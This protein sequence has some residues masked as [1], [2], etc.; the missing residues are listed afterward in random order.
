MRLCP[1]C[2][3][4][5]SDK[6]VICRACGRDVRDVPATSPDPSPIPSPSPSGTK[7]C[8]FCAED[9]QYAA[10]VCRFCGR[11]LPVDAVRP[12]SSQPPATGPLSVRRPPSPT[13]KPDIRSVKAF[14]AF[15][16]SLI[17][18]F[19]LFGLAIRS[20]AAAVGL[21]ALGTCWIA[22]VIIGRIR[23]AIPV[24]GSLSRLTLRRSG[25]AVLVGMCL[26]GGAMMGLAAGSQDRQKAAAA[27]A[28]AEATQRLAAERRVKALAAVEGQVTALQKS[29]EAK[30]WPTALRLEAS[31]RSVS[32]DRSELKA[33]A[34]V[35]AEARVEAAWSDALASARAVVS[36]KSLCDTPKAI[37]EAWNKLRALDRS[38]GDW[39]SAVSLAAR[40]ERCRKQAEMHLT[41][42]LKETMIQQRREWAKR[43]ET[44]SLDQGMDVDFTL[45]GAGR[46]H[47]KVKWALMSKAV[48]HK[49]TGGGS[50]AD[51]AFLS[52]AQKM[53]CRR[54]SFTDGWQF[55]V[56]YDLSPMD[57]STGGQTVLAQMGI[58]APLVL[59]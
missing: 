16:G 10:V 17:L 2:G 35:L 45:E 53:G 55:S 21:L 22:T 23:P 32:P 39:A 36:D 9:I 6:A 51:G 27:R 56:Y 58:G 57:E 14:G 31:I 52:S 4:A 41:A 47:L 5:M 46:D 48:V 37:S 11:D 42:G 50:M 3:K 20:A 28:A 43:M 30:D 1:H 40:L 49:I 24:V 19:F 34:P 59:R 44:A 54:V 25:W 13:A 26:F 18:F 33:L 38:K 12:A 8:P 15:V 7:K 29:V